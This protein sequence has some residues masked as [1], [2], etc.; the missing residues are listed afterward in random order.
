MTQPTYVPPKDKDLGPYDFLFKLVPM[1]E[2]VPLDV[3][4]G[5]QNPSGEKFMQDGKTLEATATEQDYK[6]LEEALV[7]DLRSFR[8]GQSYGSVALNEVGDRFLSILEYIALLDRKF[9]TDPKKVE[10]LRFAVIKAFRVKVNHGAWR[11]IPELHMKLYKKADEEVL[12]EQEEA[13]KY[14]YKQ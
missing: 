14:G 6:G 11:Y 9:N 13:K 8:S 2:K 1:W 7:G 12:R 10:A 4:A 3:I 5:S